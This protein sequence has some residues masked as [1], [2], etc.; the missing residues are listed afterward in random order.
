MIKKTV[1]AIVISF[2][3]LSGGQQAQ[4]FSCADLGALD[5]Q[6]KSESEL[7]QYLI[8]CEKEKVEIEQSLSTQKSQSAGIQTEING[9]TQIN[10]RLKA[11]IKARA[12]VITKLGG[13]IVQKEAKIETLSEKMVREQESLAQ[14]IRK[15]HTL[16]DAT[17]V[18]VA[19]GDQ[20]LSDF[21]QDFDTFA[22][23]QS[24]LKTSLDEIRGIKTETETEKK[25]LKEKQDA[26]ID[27]KVELERNKK[28][29]EKN[30]AEKKKLLSVSKQKESE[31][32]KLVA[33][34]AAKAAQIRAK[35]FSLRDTAAIPFGDALEF[36]TLASQKTGVRPAFILAILTQES[37][38][39]ANVGACYL[40]DR[41][42]GAGVGSRTG[43]VFPNVMKPS[44]DVTPFLEITAG[45]GRDWAKTL[46]SCPIAGVAGYGG[47]MGPSQFIPSTWQLIEKRIAKALNI[48]HSD[49]WNPRDAIMASGI[50]LSDLGANGQTYTTERTAACRYYS[51][52]SCYAANGKANVGLSYG[53]SVMNKVDAIQADIDALKGL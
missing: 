20:T 27:A 21:Y 17:I 22:S 11:S 38:L 15:A 29:V 23:V 3:I 14:L 16:D 6:T 5:L 30:E 7:R 25:T 48:A 10:N 32:Q 49:P 2:F 1:F 46:V 50:Y 47:A 53:N 33:E 18:H 40:T 43:T 39:G 13:D 36:A 41:E 12:G 45:V 35:L 31:Y 4:A 51:G 26:E 19:L 9:I 42:T 44:R 52:R 34:R 28:E 24:A 8:Q 37:N